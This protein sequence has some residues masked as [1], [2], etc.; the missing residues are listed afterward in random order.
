[1]PDVHPCLS[2]PGVCMHQPDCQDFDCP[3]RR[4]AIE[5]ANS[6]PCS[7]CIAGVCRTPQACIRPMQELPA[8]IERRLFTSRPDP[9]QLLRRIAIGVVVAAFL[10]AFHL[11][12][13]GVS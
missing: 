9:I 11:L 7:S 13:K 1:M 10:I 12:T 5:V 6:T 2:A 3:G 8:R 4:A